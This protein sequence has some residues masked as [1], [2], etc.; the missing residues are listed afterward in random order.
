MK[1][2]K[3]A[4]EGGIFILIWAAVSVVLGAIFSAINKTGQSTRDIIFC[5]LFLG[6]FLAFFICLFW[7]V[8]R[9]KKNVRNQRQNKSVS[10]NGT[11]RPKSPVVTSVNVVRQEVPQKTLNDMRMTYTGQQS[12][13]DMRIIDESLKIMETTSDIDTFLSRYETAMRC[14]MTLEQAKKAGV[15]IALADDFSQSLANAKNQ[16]LKGVLYR[17]LKKELDEISKLKTFNGKLNRINKYQEKL[18][19]IYETEIQFVADEVYDD[20]MQKLEFL[21]NGQNNV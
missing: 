19:A 17:S 2:Q 3:N 10:G 9:T 5:S 11:V 6:F 16:A 14:A 20:I 8:I 21:K 15:P 18:Q 13:N 12:V 1:T 4:S 7:R